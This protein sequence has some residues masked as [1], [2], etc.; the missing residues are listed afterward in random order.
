MTSPPFRLC[1]RNHMATKDAHAYCKWFRPFAEGIKRVLKGAWEP[2]IHLVVLGIPAYL[3]RSLY[4]F[5][6]L[7]MLCEEYGFHLC[8]EHY[9][10]NPSKLPGP[11]EWVN[12]RRIRVK[13]AVNCVWWLSPT[14]WPKA[15]N[16]RVLA[17]YS[18]SMR[19]LLLNGY[20]A[21]R[22]PSGHRISKKFAKDNGGA[23]PPICWPLPTVN[24][25]ASIRIIVATTI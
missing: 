16:R 22:R 1:E 18:E 17:P 15:S 21:K 3:T 24:Q 4:H 5:E 14:P 6:L 12:V 10:W 23:V 7:I 13:D 25:T 2:G 11:A 20:N 8:Q 9:W 19:D